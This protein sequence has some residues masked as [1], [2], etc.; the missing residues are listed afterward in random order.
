MDDGRLEKNGPGIK[1]IVFYLIIIGVELRSK[2]WE[3]KKDQFV[4]NEFFK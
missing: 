2:Y 3:R 1:E 4:L